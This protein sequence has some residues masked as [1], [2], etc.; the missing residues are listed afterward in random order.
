MEI[1]K[2]TILKETDRLQDKKYDTKEQNNKETLDTERSSLF[3]F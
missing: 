2:L 3:N 1:N